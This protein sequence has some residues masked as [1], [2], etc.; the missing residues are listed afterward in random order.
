MKAYFL[1]VEVEIKQRNLEEGYYAKS[2]DLVIELRYESS[3]DTSK[4]TNANIMQQIR[5]QLKDLTKIKTMK[6]KTVNERRKKRLK[7]TEGGTISKYAAK[8]LAQY[9]DQANETKNKA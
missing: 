7:K 3:G 8:K 9:E 5:N 6:R 1:N 4:I 2:E